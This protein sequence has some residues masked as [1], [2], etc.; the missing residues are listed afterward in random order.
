MKYS[1][2]KSRFRQ[3]CLE[4]D[5]DEDRALF[6]LA[7]LLFD[8]HMNVLVISTPSEYKLLR[9]WKTHPSD[10]MLNASWEASYSKPPEWFENKVR[11]AADRAGY[12]KSE[13][14]VF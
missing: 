3:I 1:I 5:A 2:Q 8:A 6:Y 13:A 4:V 9:T 11:E 14:R 10:E 7:E 12:V